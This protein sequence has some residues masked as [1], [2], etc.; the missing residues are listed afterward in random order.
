[1]GI[2]NDVMWLKVN[3]LS[4]INY[5]MFLICGFW[6]LLLLYERIEMLFNVCKYFY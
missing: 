5:R 2:V 3:L 6:N 4:I 1:M